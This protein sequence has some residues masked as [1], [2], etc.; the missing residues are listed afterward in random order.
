MV[1]FKYRDIELSGTFINNNFQNNSELFEDK[2]DFQGIKKSCEDDAF[3]EFKKLVQI[4]IDSHYKEY[5]FG[6]TGD[7]IDLHRAL[8][9]IAKWFKYNKKEGFE[10]GYDFRDRMKKN[11]NIRPVSDWK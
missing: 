8:L 11:L 7:D 9:V 1:N 3:E 4:I 6:D 10:I 2:P 5:F